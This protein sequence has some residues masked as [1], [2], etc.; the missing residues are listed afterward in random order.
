MAQQAFPQWQQNWND[1]LDKIDSEI[2]DCCRNGSGQ[3][4][5]VFEKVRGRI[6]PLLEKGSDAGLFEAGGQFEGELR[7]RVQDRVS[8]LERQGRIPKQQTTRG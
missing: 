4:D 7:S 3:P 6:A 8:T 2:V 1:Q 5:E